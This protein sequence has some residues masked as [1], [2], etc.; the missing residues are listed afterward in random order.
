[1][2]RVP[3][4]WSAAVGDGVTLLKRRSRGGVEYLGTCAPAAPPAQVKCNGF[5][6]PAL[7]ESSAPLTAIMGSMNRAERW[8][9]RLSRSD[10]IEGHRV[11]S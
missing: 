3:V 7:D 6:S 8:Q 4:D 2:W 5:A 11:I 1:M 9:S 10:E